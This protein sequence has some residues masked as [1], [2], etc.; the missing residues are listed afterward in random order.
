MVCFEFEINVG[1]ELEGRHCANGTNFVNR[2]PGTNYLKGLTGGGSI[3]KVYA[4]MTF[5]DK[6]RTNR[7]TAIHVLHTADAFGS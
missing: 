6:L 1:S 4:D 5:L 3:N 2:F 7:A